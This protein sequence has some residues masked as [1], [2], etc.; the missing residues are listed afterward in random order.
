M[1]LILTVVIVGALIGVGMTILAPLVKQTKYN[2][3]GRRIDSAIDAIVSWSAANGRLPDSALFASVVK[4]TE[5]PWRRPLVYVYDNALTAAPSG[6]ICG[7]QTTGIAYGAIADVA[8]VIISGGDDYSVGSTPNAGGA[9]TGNILAAAA[10]VVHHVTL[11]DLKAR[12]GCYGGTAGRL[13]LINKELPTACTG[14]AYVADIHADGG[15]PFSS[16]GNYKWCLK[17]ALPA[18]LSTLPTTPACLGTADCMALG[19]E[20]ASQWSQATTLQV[21][22]TP[23]GAG[24]AAV[25]ILARDNNDGNTG[26]SSDNCVQMTYQVTVNNCGGGPPPVSQWDFNEGSGTTAG[27]GVGGHDGTIV[28]DVAWTG[29]TPDG[30][31]AALSFDGTGDFVRIAH[32]D[33][34]RITD[35][36]TLAAWVKAT[37][38]HPFA[39]VIS[40]RS[41][42]YFYFLG[43]DN[44]SPYGGVGDGTTFAVTGKSLLMSLQA[45]NHMAFVYNHAEDTMFI[46]FDGTERET[47][48]A[49]VLPALAGVDISIGADSA[50]TAAFFTGALDDV[51][52]Y[53]RALSAAEIR[54]ITR[55]TLNE[56]PV[57]LYAFN[58]DATDG[59]GNG[60]DGVITGASFT[61]DRSGNSNKAMAFDGNDTVRIGDHVDF[62]L[63]GQLT[64]MAWVNETTPGAFAKVLSRRSGSYF[65][66]LGVDSGHPYGGIGDGTSI[67]VTR[68]SIAMAPGKWHHIAFVYSQAAGTIHIYY[69]G[70]VDETA[71]SIILPDMAG[72]A[73]T[74]GGDSEGTGNFFEG[75][76]DGVAVYDIA[77]TAD[78]IRQTY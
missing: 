15:V 3:A 43:V 54:A 76:I 27:D 65:Y 9:F 10:D 78:E 25:T 46:H 13:R 16:G 75:L 49:L 18:G 61:Q 60:H 31:G 22:G 68:K 38:D 40:R 12:A 5:D 36:L 6:G 21:S 67:A 35:E 70:I 72:I 66:F 71:V 64:V 73:L 23:S 37:A 11:A 41:G 14:Q 2:E 56:P 47:A 52:V 58:G 32:P 24:A 62:R 33:Q 63:T 1:P 55:G 59:S 51:A 39:K 19:T 44:G 28:G 7:R 4:D 42:N 34:F 77:L 50:G 48:T 20:A 30:T 26:T 45:W 17:G 69:D 8:F 74:I 53:A 29:D 57:A